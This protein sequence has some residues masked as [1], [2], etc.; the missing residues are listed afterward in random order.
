MKRLLNIIRNIKKSIEAIEKLETPGEEL[1]EN[2]SS[3]EDDTSEIKE[4]L[5]SAARYEEEGLYEE[6]VKEYE[7]ALNVSPENIEIYNSLSILYYENGDRD[8]AIDY[9]SKIVNIYPD[10][11]WAH[12]NLATIYKELGEIKEALFHYNKVVDLGDEEES[13]FAFCNMGLI[14]YQDKKYEEAA[15]KLS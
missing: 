6:A 4:F 1:C 7:K 2:F 8:E 5:H 10:C 3:E 15:K 14:N 9:C 11:S 13:S 12:N